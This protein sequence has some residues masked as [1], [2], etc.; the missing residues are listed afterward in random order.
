MAQWLLRLA[1]MKVRTVLILCCVAWSLA[2][3]AGAWVL[4]SYEGKSGRSG[5]TPAQWPVDAVVKGQAN[6]PTL[7]MFAHPQCPCTRASISELNRL[8]ARC[9]GKLTAHVFFLHPDGMPQDWT[10][11][12]LWQSAAAIPGVQ[13]HADMDGQEARRFGAECSGQVVLYD[14]HGA[15]VFRGGITMARGHEGD[16]AGENVI[17]TVVNGG[18]ASLHETPVFGC[19][20]LDMAEVAENRR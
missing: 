9:A 18:K 6:Q 17:I 12:G 3:G 10:K 15:L 11:G 7:V 13:V 20:L 2:A 8:M 4:T 5:A 19:G 16:N 1:R 14:A